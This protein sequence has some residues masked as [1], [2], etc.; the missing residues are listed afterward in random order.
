MAS[1][2]RKRKVKKPRNLVVLVMLL[3]RKGGKMKDRRAGRKGER[4]REELNED[5]Q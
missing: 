3:T 4:E 2:R 1:K 5:E